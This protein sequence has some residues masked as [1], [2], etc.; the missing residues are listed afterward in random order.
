M[1][2]IDYHAIANTGVAMQDA[3]NALITL[4]SAMDSPLNPPSVIIAP[5]GIPISDTEYY[6]AFHYEAYSM[7]LD[8]PILPSR[9][10]DV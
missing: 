10:V 7:D 8:K 3:A 4:N 6:E 1:G 2:E 9:F 5:D